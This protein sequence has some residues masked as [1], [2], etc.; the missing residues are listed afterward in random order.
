MYGNAPPPGE[1]TDRVRTVPSQASITDSL[2]T[3]IT[4]SPENTTSNNLW[5]AFHH[6]PYASLKYY[7][8]RI[9][10][11]REFDDVRMIGIDRPSI[12]NFVILRMMNCG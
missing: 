9:K 3:T 11:V 6:L 4:R 10:T 8:V 1:Y 12:V 5:C 7:V 2:R